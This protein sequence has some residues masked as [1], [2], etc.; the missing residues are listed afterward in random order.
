MNFYFPNRPREIGFDLA[1]GRIAL[2][3]ILIAA[4]WDIDFLRSLAQLPVSF[5]LFDELS[6]PHIYQFGSFFLKEEV[7]QSY[8]IALLCGLFGIATPI[9]IFYVALL[10]VF[11]TSFSF[12]FGF[13]FHNTL[14]LAFVLLILVFSGS[15]ERLSVDSIVLRAL[16]CGHM[17]GL[18]FRQRTALQAIRL[19]FVAMVFLAGLA[20]I[21]FTGVSWF[22]SNFLMHQ[23]IIYNVQSKDGALFEFQQYLNAYL[24]SRPSL[25][26]GIA[27]LTVVL[28]LCSPLAVLS[29]RLYYKFL[30]AFGLFQI[31]VF[32]VMYVNFLPW[33][34]LYVFWPP[35]LHVL[36]RVR[37]LARSFSLRG[38]VAVWYQR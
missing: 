25:L 26:R 15:G 23:L 1:V 16:K 28:D 8:N 9:A 5:R 13:S 37:D 6:I 31:T 19:V 14:P 24:V 18:L 22:T 7:R 2:F 17:K 12:S 20:K 29:R 34:G 4:T 27:L 11:G 10:F 21:R 33:F 35:W 36:R 30:L 3:A 32:I 38:L